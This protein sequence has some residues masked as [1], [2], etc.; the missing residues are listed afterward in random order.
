MSISLLSLLLL[1]APKGAATLVNFFLKRYCDSF[2]NNE[3]IY[4]D[5]GRERRYPMRHTGP[6]TDLD[7]LIFDAEDGGP[8][9][10]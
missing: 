1:R 9:E 3:V 8:S 2:F 6:Y 10:R 7:D 4:C 5:L